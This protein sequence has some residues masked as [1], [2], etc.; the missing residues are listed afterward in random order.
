[1]MTA[2]KIVTIAQLTFRRLDFILLSK[3]L[4]MR[5]Y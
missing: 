3:L 4:Q 1:M 2:E 5:A